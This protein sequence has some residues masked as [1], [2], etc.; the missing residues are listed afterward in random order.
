MFY[1]GA[2]HTGSITLEPSKV[3]AGVWIKKVG[4]WWLT[5]VERNIVV[6]AEKGII[7]ESYN[8]VKQNYCFEC[9]DTKK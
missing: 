7:S 8:E 1:L 3:T 5:Y 9:A 4:L 6:P 2:A